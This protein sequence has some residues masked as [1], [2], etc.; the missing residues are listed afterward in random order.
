[1]KPENRIIALGVDAGSHSPS[2]CLSIGEFGAVI[3][4]RNG[5]GKTRFLKQ[6]GRSID[7][8]YERRNHPRLFGGIITPM[9]RE[10]PWHVADD[11]N[12]LYVNPHSQFLDT[13]NFLRNLESSAHE[14]DRDIELTSRSS[15]WQTLQ[16]IEPSSFE[17]ISMIYAAMGL[18]ESPSLASHYPYLLAMFSEIAQV[19]S[20]GV[21]AID[22]PH[23]VGVR[24]W[25]NAEPDSTPFLN[26]VIENINKH[27][28]RELVI[29]GPE[30]NPDNE[31]L[32]DVPIDLRNLVES[33]AILLDR[34]PGEG[35]FEYATPLL[36][37]AGFVLGN[38]VVEGDSPSVPLEG[39]RVSLRGAP[40][41]GI[42]SLEH[43]TSYR[44][45][46][47]FTWVSGEHLGE[48]ESDDDDSKS[49][50]SSILNSFSQNPVLKT[51]YAPLLSDSSPRVYQF[52]EHVWRFACALSDVSRA[53]FQLLLPES[54]SI[55]LADHNGQLNWRAQIAGSN[56]VSIFDLS[57]VQ[58]RWATL[59]IQLAYRY[60]DRLAA[61]IETAG[62]SIGNVDWIKKNL[63]PQFIGIDRQYPGDLL[64]IDEPEKGLHR[65]AEAP[66]AA[67]LITLARVCGFKPLI[68]SHSP[69]FIRTFKAA[70]AN[71][72]WTHQNPAGE[73]AIEALDWG[74]LEV[75]SEASGLTAV[76]ALELIRTFLFVEGEHDRAVISGLFSD[77]L[78]D[79]G[80]AVIPLRGVRGLS[81][82]V[83]S[84]LLW[85]FTNAKV[86]LLLD[87]LD[88]PNIQ[89]L[90]ERVSLLSNRGR[91]TEA[92]LEI[93]TLDQVQGTGA[94]E[95]K[96]IRELFSSAVQ[97][98]LTGRIHILGLREPDIINYFHP[99]EL[100]SFHD[101]GVQRN[102]DRSTLWKLLS[103]EWRKSKSNLGFKTWLCERFPGTRIDAHVLENA[104]RKWDSI[105]SDFVNL[106]SE[107][108]RL[109]E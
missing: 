108:R 10:Q 89:Q 49:E 101:P 34:R 51:E 98:G 4:G 40:F 70:G 55:F 60:L 17:T 48:G 76:D 92:M 33:P 45:K 78:R 42:E 75:L 1:M 69:T 16:S 35:L 106:L 97:H 28:G 18:E 5:A 94:S 15:L 53:V 57:E 3:I 61:L 47:S 90:W 52:P 80:I 65:A 84:A 12:L 54:P 8:I 50:L 6:I 29:G 73:T 13:L 102:I 41:V 46:Q 93:E 87:H 91:R 2:R 39:L 96:A 107:L 26:H 20:P 59:A 43:D 7:L 72:L 25:Y 24:L 63:E 62:K 71:L 14:S 23:S 37:L 104:T 38:P 109:S 81:Q 56:S 105:P 36:P 11:N 22:K 32:D 99:C 103:K 64:L 77:E 74:D 21:N 100:I 86:C 85:R 82:V 67:G 95:K 88:G 31:Y 44:F 30:S 27:D 66:I 9:E 68:V 83:D 19:S 79:L 58:Q